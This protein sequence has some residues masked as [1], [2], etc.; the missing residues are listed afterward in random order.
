MVICRAVLAAH[1]KVLRD[2][3][4]THYEPEGD[5]TWVEMHALGP[6]ERILRA[7]L[8]LAGGRLTVETMS[9]PRMERVLERLQREVPDIT[10]V[11]DV[12]RPLEPGE[13]PPLPRHIGAASIDPADMAGAM[14]A[15]QD[16]MERRWCEEVV[17]AL[18]GLTPRQAAADPTRRETLER[19][20]TEFE[21]RGGRLPPGGIT[22]RPDRIREL[23]GLRD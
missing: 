15:V 13:M 2:V 19:L 17:P 9:E 8:Q 5:E 23:L 21:Q 6:D 4:D 20:L 22:M 18:G 1:P 12:R 7:T 3:L 11:S 16:Q 14:E 10:V